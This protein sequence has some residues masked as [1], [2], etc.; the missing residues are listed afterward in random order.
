[1]NELIKEVDD[2]EITSKKSYITLVIFYIGAFFFLVR[3]FNNSEIDGKF[4]KI[5]II[6]GLIIISSTLLFRFF[7]TKSKL[8]ISNNK[9][10]IDIT[11]GFPQKVEKH[12]FELKNIERIILK[13]TH[14]TKTGSKKVKI[15]VK[16]GC[17]EINVT[18]RYYQLVQIE[19]Y[20]KN[21]TSIH[22]ELIG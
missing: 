13:Q 18:F 20:F 9:I 4:F 2:F 3:T 17:H 1:M 10:F 15:Y 21:N 12:S 8:T 14:E 5:F 16:E 11:Y 7:T 19:E 22:A 6:L